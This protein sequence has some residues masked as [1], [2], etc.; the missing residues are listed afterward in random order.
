MLINVAAAEKVLEKKVLCTNW[1]KK[2]GWSSQANGGGQF[3]NL[4]HLFF[5]FL[6]LLR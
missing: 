6:C 5:V 4:Q 3:M 2:Q 1:K